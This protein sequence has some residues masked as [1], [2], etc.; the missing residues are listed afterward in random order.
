MVIKNKNPG[1]KENHTERRLKGRCGNTLRVLAVLS[2]LIGMIVVLP[3]QAIQASS[4]P[5]P[6]LLVTNSA[7]TSNVFGPFLGEILRGRRP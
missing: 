6:I 2:I 5:D 1:K 3:P 7:Y 4:L